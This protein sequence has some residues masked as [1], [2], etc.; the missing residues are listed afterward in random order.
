MSPSP[1]QGC[2]SDCGLPLATED[3]AA[4]LCLHCLGR[5]AQTELSAEFEGPPVPAT[6]A[7][8]LAPGV[9]LGGR[10][11]LHSWLGVGGVG[12]VWRAFDLVL[13]TEVALKSVRAALLASAEARESLRREALLSRAVISRHVCRV[14][15]LHVLDS[16]EWIAMEF[17]DGISLAEVLRQRGPLPLD[18]A[19]DLALQFLAGLEAIHEADLLHRDLKPENLMVTRDGRVVVMDLGTAKSAETGRTRRVAGTPAYMS[20][21]QGRGEALD[22]RADVFSAGVVLAEMVAPGGLASVEDRRRLWQGIH[23]DVPD[24]ANTP[25]Q[26]V[27]ARAVTA[28]REQRLESAT[29]LATALEAITRGSKPAGRREP[30]A[31]LGSNFFRQRRL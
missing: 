17:V 10:F 22:V 25:W 11:R 23:A 27:I 28:D 8:A 14:F 16:R 3:W 13:Q 24:L 4:G 29:A 30:P 12:E 21:E 2:C 31:F 20:P 1:P 9:V 19:E 5:L 6:P 26:D 7:T 15:D 18:E